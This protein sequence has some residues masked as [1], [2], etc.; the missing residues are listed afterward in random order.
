MAGTRKIFRPPLWGTIALV[1]AGTV[2]ISAGIW[3]M[4]RV[5]QKRRIFATFDMAADNE[6]LRELVS[7]GQTDKF[8]YRHFRV[9]GRYDGEHQILIDNMIHNGRAGY[10]V[11]TPLRGGGKAVLINRGWVPADP[12]RAILPV[13]SVDDDLREVTG[14]LSLLPRP[15]IRL[16]ASRLLSASSWPRRLLYPKAEEIIDQLDY[17]IFDYQLLLD[18]DDTDGFV[19]DWRPAIMGPDRHIGYAIQWFALAF[20]L[21]VIYFFVNWKTAD[22]MQGDSPRQ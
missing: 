14:R 11:L 3:Q 2:C 19:R 5:E 16:E 13:I 12:N 22:E 10:Q 4:D 17:V 9:S 21:L 20:T 15:G 6:V 1:L 8:R 7:N 18:P